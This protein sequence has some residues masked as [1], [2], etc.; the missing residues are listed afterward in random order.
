MAAIAV[1]RKSPGPRQEG[2]WAIIN[3]LPVSIGKW[4]RKG[5]ILIAQLVRRGRADCYL[6]NVERSI[7]SPRMSDPTFSRPHLRGQPIELRQSAGRDTP[8]LI[9]DLQR[10]IDYQSDLVPGQVFGFGFWPVRISDDAGKL[11]FEEYDFFNETFRPDLLHS[12]L[13]WQLQSSVAHKSSEP[14]TSF[15]VQDAVFCS[16]DILEPDFSGSIAGERRV[17]EVEGL[18]GWTVWNDTDGVDVTGRKF[19]AIRFTDLLRMSNFDILEH[20]G[21]PVGYMFKTQP[22]AES[23]VFPAPD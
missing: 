4:D 9:A 14:W 21:L 1:A 8:G 11:V 7:Y 5:C 19:L 12:V 2:R 10:F 22:G 3:L 23:A 16:S 18:S 20:M 17:P 15:S 13:L 6:V